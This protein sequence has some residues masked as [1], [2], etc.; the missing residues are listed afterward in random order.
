MV[1]TRL[2]EFYLQRFNEYIFYLISSADKSY[3][4]IGDMTS[5]IIK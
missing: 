3:L 4:I 5:S 1:S 2:I